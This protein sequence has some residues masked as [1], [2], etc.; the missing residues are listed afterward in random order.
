MEELAKEYESLCGKKSDINEHLPTLY[1][2]AM[3]SSVVLELGVRNCVS[4]WALALGLV[5]NNN[6][7][8]KLIVNDILECDIGKF[9]K[10]IKKTDIELEKYWQN[11]L[12]LNLNEKVDLLFIDTWHIYGQLRRELE[13]FHS[14]VN[15]H[16]ILHDTT[17]F[18]TRPEPARHAI[19]K[20]SMETFNITKD[21]IKKGIQPAID[22]FLTKHSEW[23]VK[24]VFTNNNGL[25]I[26]ERKE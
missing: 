26:L 3:E 17:T 4:T 6:V 20:H 25:T 7:S 11:D 24:E 16:I 23:K 8:K 10:I 22:E 15:K 18:G 5:R 21:E 14:I 2:Y 19:I 13:K 1:K 12:T 9:E